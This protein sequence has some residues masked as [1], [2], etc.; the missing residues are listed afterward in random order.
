MSTFS[1]AS[2]SCTKTDGH[3]SPSEKGDSYVIR[4][5]FHGVWEVTDTTLKEYVIRA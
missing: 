5:G 2:R 1:W 4:P 3:R